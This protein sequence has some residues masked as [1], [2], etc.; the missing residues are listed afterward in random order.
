[1]R[2]LVC[3]AV[4]PCFELATCPLMFSRLLLLSSRW[5]RHTPAWWKS[6]LQWICGN[7]SGFVGPSDHT[8]RPEMKPLVLQVVV[9]KAGGQASQQAFLASPPLIHP[10]C[11]AECYHLGGQSSVSG[12]QGD[13]SWDRSR[14]KEMLPHTFTW[15]PPICCASGAAIS[16]ALSTASPHFDPTIGPPAAEPGLVGEL[17]AADTETLNMKLQRLGGRGSKQESIHENQCFWHWWR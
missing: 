10:L 13:L 16:E 2:R 4:C 14:A 7:C 17:N 6:N 12:P 15:P 1:M 8:S 3:L 11:G 5:S 9:R